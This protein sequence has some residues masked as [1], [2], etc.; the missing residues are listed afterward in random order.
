MSGFL[1]VIARRRDGL[2]NS[3]A[4]LRLL[5]E[6]AAS[7]SIPDEQLAAW[8]MAA[9]LRPLDEQETAWLTVAMS[10]SG[11][12]LDLTGLPKPW[13]DKHSTGG[14]GDK[15]TI[16]LLP[17]LAAC[18][19]TVVKMSG[20][21]LGI[22]GGTVDKL[23]SIPGFRMDLSPTEMI[24]QAER[25][26]LA[27][28]GQ[29]PK[30]APADKKL[31]ALRD[32]TA[33]VG[34]MPLIVSSILSKKLA[35]G[36]ESIVLDVK[37]GSGAFMKT[38]GEARAL[39]QLLVDTARLAGLPTRAL[40][41]DMS[42]P[43][44]VAVGNALEVAEAIEVLQGRGNA[45]LR[46]L[47]LE[48]ASLTLDATGLALSHAEGL[49][50]AS[51]ALYEGTALDKARAWFKAQG[52]AVD[53]IDIARVLPRAAI[54]REVRAESDGWVAELDA[55]TIGQAVIDLG[56]GRK[57]KE[58]HV[59]PAVGIECL[60]HVGDHVAKG[61]VVARIHAADEVAASQA[62][63]RVRAALSLVDGVPDPRPLILERF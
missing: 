1:D 5:S 21:G 30:L 15:T 43:L 11:E 44:G 55:G 60:L 49:E 56:G 41:T 27:I 47:C 23:E 6:G 39:A 8:L 45:R 2:G 62:E 42:Q 22:T 50:R 38:L 26:G 28:T 16:I 24:D 63:L 20:R 58:D 53:A 4:D 32:V 17:L 18:G 57:R 9:Y 12:R 36:A 46:T 33:T 31:Y 37:S 34:S 51:A 25:I 59:D 7:G 40:V 54:V 3:E 52:C 29:T 61:G 14:V 48:L 19:L 35:G 13:V 10:Q